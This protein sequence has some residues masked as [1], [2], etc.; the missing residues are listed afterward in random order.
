MLSGGEI[1]LA[2]AEAMDRGQAERLMP[3]L[4]EVLAKAGIGWGD[5]DAL[6]VGTG[7]GNFTGVRIAVAAARG[8][9]LGLDVPAIGV[10]GL[11]ALAH[12]AP[13]PVTV[14]LPAPREQVYEQVFD[15]GGANAA[16]LMPGRA[17]APDPVALASALARVAAGR[18]GAGG[19]GFGRPAPLYIRPA[20]AAPPREAP[21]AILP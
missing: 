14:R 8:L 18:F 11:D 6:A 21:P 10:T 12:D 13:R 20:D 9:A 3:F 17:T 19:G 7:P 2:R 15:G 5:L 4:E 1:V 16:R